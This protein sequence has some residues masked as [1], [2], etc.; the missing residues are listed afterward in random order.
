MKRDPQKAAVARLFL[1]L[2]DDPEVKRKMNTIR[3]TGR[4][5]SKHAT[6]LAKALRA[7][8]EDQAR[9]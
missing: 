9:L 4:Q 3:T 5:L 6:N 7:A 8:L 2:L 1:E